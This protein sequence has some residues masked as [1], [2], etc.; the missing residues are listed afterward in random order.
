MWLYICTLI[1][2]HSVLVQFCIRN[3]GFSLVTSHS[4][5]L[6][7]GPRVQGTDNSPIEVFIV[8]ALSWWHLCHLETWRQGA[9]S[10]PWT[11]EWPVR[12]DPVHQG[13]RVCMKDLFLS[14]TPMWRRKE[15][16]WPQVFAGSPPTQTSTST[17]HHHPKVKSGIVDCLL[18]RAERI[19]KQDSM[20]C[21]WD[22]EGPYGAVLEIH[23]RRPMMNLD[24]G[25]ILD[26][27]WIPFVCAKDGSHV[28]E[29][30]TSWRSN[31]M[32]VRGTFFVVARTHWWRPS[33]LKRA[34]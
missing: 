11:S 31:P 2:S 4:Q 12:R 26:P 33:V 8:V 3:H 25:L 20:L 19:C 14:S 9:T 18:N 21:W 1:Y 34:R 6:N 30:T 32:Y 13:E 15:A 17:S 5:R 10:F 24:A 16:K 28:T 23:Q 7:A 29:S 27:P 22:A